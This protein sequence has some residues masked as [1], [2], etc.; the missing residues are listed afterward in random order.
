MA[1]LRAEAA[2]QRLRY[3]EVMRVTVEAASLEWTVEISKCPVS[4]A[5]MAIWAVS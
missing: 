1:A 3:H 4:A 2:G 5:S